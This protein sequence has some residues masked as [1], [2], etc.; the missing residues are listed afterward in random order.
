VNKTGHLDLLTTLTFLL[1]CCVAAHA[2]M[3]LTLQEAEQ[4]AL[5]N[6]PRVSQAQFQVKALDEVT[7]EF[8]SAYYPTVEGNLTAVGA[9]NGSRIAAGGLNNPV[10]Y[11]RVGTG[12]TLGQL[13]TDFGRTQ[14]LVGSA[15]LN[16]QAQREALSFTKADLLLRTDGAYLAVLRNH[17]LLNVAQ[18]TVDARQQVVDQVSALFNSKLKSSLDLSFANVNLADAK[19]LLS[20]AQNNLR[21]AEAEL[22]QLLAVPVETSFDLASPG[23]QPALPPNSADLVASALRTRPDLNMQRLQVESSQKFAQAERDLKRPTVSLL[24]TAGYVPAGET[25]IPGTYGAL[26]LNVAVPVFNGGLFHAREF[27]ADARAAAAEKGMQNLELEIS[28]DVRT[29]WLNARNSYDQV[30]LTQQLFD[31]AKLALDLAQARYK[32]GLSSIVELSQSQLQYTSAEIQ[33][34][35]AE[36]DYFAQSRVLDFET[37][38][39]H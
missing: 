38:A 16:A 25:Q 36:Y 24:G 35:R 37:G 21:S 3:K 9:D 39:L 33:H 29:A 14:N 17:S 4:L 6:N 15:S 5:K 22:A 20:S 27:E 1:L 18:E 32:L 31:Q 19:L 34:A 12:L 2:Q 28:R 26:G 30:Q 7:R 23:P 8:R 10:V 13:I 11:D